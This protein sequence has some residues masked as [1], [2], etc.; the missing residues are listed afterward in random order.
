M[1]DIKYTKQAIRE[2]PNLKS[3]NLDNTAKQLIGIIERNP[4]QNPPPYEKLKGNLW[5]R[6][7]DAL[8]ESTDLYMKFW[9][10]KTL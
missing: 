5:E 9:N 2:I 3:V 8:I 6:I 7:R 10:Q 1:F 4:F